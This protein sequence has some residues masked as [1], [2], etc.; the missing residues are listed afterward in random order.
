[1]LKRVNFCVYYSQYRK[2]PHVL[3]CIK[4][5][6]FERFSAALALLLTGNIWAE[7]PASRDEV[8]HL[9]GQTGKV[10]RQ[11]KKARADG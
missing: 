6:F 4:G 3:V 2:E 11:M 7:R 5:S 10:L 8:R 9:F 1:M